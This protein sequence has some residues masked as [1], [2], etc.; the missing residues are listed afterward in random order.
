M[1]SSLKWKTLT[2]FQIW[3]IR[4]M[5]W[6]IAKNYFLPHYHRNVYKEERSF[7]AQIQQKYHEYHIKSVN[8]P[9]LNLICVDKWC[10]ARA[11][12]RVPKSSGLITEKGTK[13]K[14]NG[15]KQKLYKFNFGDPK[16][17]NLSNFSVLAE[18][19][20]PYSEHFISIIWAN[21]YHLILNFQRYNMMSFIFWS[22]K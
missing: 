21:L 1:I 3:K 7:H 16:A 22:D 2:K 19:S 17:R 8:S 4:K 6:K 11:L 14:P 13:T 12:L 18:N 10:P 15:S 20:P 9:T 5:L